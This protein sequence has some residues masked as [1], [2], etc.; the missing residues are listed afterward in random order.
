MGCDDGEEEEGRRRQIVGRIYLG[1]KGK[2]YGSMVLVL[3][4]R[5]MCEMF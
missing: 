3:L 5:D 1:S 2:C 4:V